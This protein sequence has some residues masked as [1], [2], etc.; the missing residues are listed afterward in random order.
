[1][2]DST[3]V[4]IGEQQITWAVRQVRPSLTAMMDTRPMKIILLTLA[5]SGLVSTP[6]DAQQ[7]PDTPDLAAVTDARSW[8]VFHATAETMEMDGRRAVRLVAEGDSAN[9]LV[10]LALPMSVRFST[11][12]I[13]IDLKGK[14]I[15]QR[16]FLGVAFNVAD[17][18]T[19]EA[20]YFRPF[21]FKAEEPMRGRSVQYVAWPANTWEHLR[22]TAPGQFENPVHPVPDPDSWFHAR[23]EVTEK[24]VRVFVGDASEPTLMVS[25]LLPGGQRRPAGLFVDSAEGLYANL[26]ITPDK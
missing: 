19:F 12:T 4:R 5:L 14:N 2:R 7:K 3:P 23:I 17:E 24:Q 11:G 22:K 16:S 26:R 13:E 1:M 10:G 21:N 8:K 15:R 20:V 18:R 6:V 25:R 9:G